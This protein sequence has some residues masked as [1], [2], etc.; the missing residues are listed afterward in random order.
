M[1]KEA[2]PLCFIIFSYK[3][4]DPRLFFINRKL[5]KRFVDKQKK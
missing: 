1:K 2:G 5:A 3:H 4:L